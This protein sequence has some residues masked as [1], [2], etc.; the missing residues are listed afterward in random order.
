MR[1]YT[2]ITFRINKEKLE[3]EMKEKDKIIAKNEQEYAEAL[4]KLEKKSVLD[5]DRWHCDSKL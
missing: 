2:C 4:Y 3:A 5:K 1:V